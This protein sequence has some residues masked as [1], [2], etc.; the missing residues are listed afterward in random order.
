MFMSIYM[1]MYICVYIYAHASSGDRSG[2]PPQDIL[3]AA[4]IGTD[5]VKALV[6]AG[7]DINVKDLEGQGDAVHRGRADGVLTT[8]GHIDK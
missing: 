5:A 6:A 2:C 8:Y 1:Y 7:A 4:E 3:D